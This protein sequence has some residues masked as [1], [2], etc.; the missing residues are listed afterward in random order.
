[1][2]A[3]RRRHVGAEHFEVFVGDVVG[4]EL[5]RGRAGAFRAGQGDHGVERR[6]LQEVLAEHEALGAQRV[7]HLGRDPVRVLEDV[8]RQ[9]VLDLIGHCGHRGH[10]LLKT[11]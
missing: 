8:L 4:E 5:R 6:A 2:R 3:Q 9:R 11:L 10:V 7:Q 1:V